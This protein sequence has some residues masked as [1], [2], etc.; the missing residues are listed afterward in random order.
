MKVSIEE[1]KQFKYRVNPEEH[2]GPYGYYFFRPLSLYLT[3]LALRLGLT[4]NQVTVSQTIVGLMGV[5]F[6]ASPTPTLTITGLLLLQCG[7]MLD[8]VDGEVARFR[9][10]VSITGKFLDAI[11]H[12]LVVM[13]MYFS[14]GIGTY[15]RL[16]HFETVV[17]GF[18][19]GF[20]SLRLDISTMYL[21]AARFV[22]TR[23]D[24]SYEYYRGLQFGEHLKL[25]RQGKDEQS[26]KRVIYGLF[27]YPATMNIVTVLVLADLLLAPI[28]LFDYKISLIYVFLTLYGILVPIRRVY[29]VWKLTKGREVE[30]KYLSLIDLLRGQERP[31]SKEEAQQSIR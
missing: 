28:D 12:E 6:L 2:Q 31:K 8:N 30:R 10:Q 5:A 7:Y 21:E 22:E 15:F 1:L 18:M 26:R 19:A 17:F 4:A 24:R 29:T 27:A 3:Y 14:L 13:G 25:H 9:N 23:L 11:N 16:G 20:F